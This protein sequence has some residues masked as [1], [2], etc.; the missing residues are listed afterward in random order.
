MDIATDHLSAK[1]NKHKG[2][3]ISNQT[4][5]EPRPGRQELHSSINAGFKAPGKLKACSKHP[6]VRQ[7]SKL[8]IS[9]SSAAI[10]AAIATTNCSSLVPAI[11]KGDWSRHLPY[12]IHWG[13]FC[14]LQ[15]NK[16]RPVQ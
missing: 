13:L 12:C 16:A 8:L 1:N 3:N 15:R 6:P 7:Y 10:A 5:H 14:N 9:F 4:L 11:I 2:G